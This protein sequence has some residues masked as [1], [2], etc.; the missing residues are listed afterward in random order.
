MKDAASITATAQDAYDSLVAKYKEYFVSIVDEA[1]EQ[2]D[3]TGDTN[4]EELIEIAGEIFG[5]IGEKCA[6]ES[7]SHSTQINT[8]VIASI[9]NNSI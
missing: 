9:G 8:T 5:K 2:A 6:N 3:I 1:V 4:Y 7:C